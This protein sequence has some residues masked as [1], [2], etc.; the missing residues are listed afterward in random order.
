MGPW[1]AF[2]QFIFWFIK[3]LY[4]FSGDWGV[5]IIIATVIIRILIFP[6]ANKQ[7]KSSYIMGQL[8]PQIQEI[9][10]KYAGDQERIQQETQRI[11]SEN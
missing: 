7:F 5:A 11:Y 4:Q 2:K 3:E 9:Q 1:A 10:K 6:I 8:Q